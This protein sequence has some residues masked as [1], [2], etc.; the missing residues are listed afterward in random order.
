MKNQYKKH[1]IEK[2]NPTEEFIM[3]VDEATNNGIFCL[4]GIIIERSYYEDIVIKEIN[5][6]KN[7]F[8]EKTDIIFHYTEIKKSHKDFIRLTDPDIR[9]KFYMVLKKFFKNSQTTVISTYFY[10]D[11]MKNLYGKCCTSQYNVAFKY[12]IEN[13]VH[14]LSEHNGNGMI[15][16]ESRLL[17]ENSFLQ[18]SFYDYL[19]N[20]SELFS[21]KTISSYLKCLGFTV[22]GDNCIGLQLADFI[23]P[24][25]I[26]II[27]DSKDKFGI[28]GAIRSKIYKND[29]EYMSTLG[30][31][32]I[33][34]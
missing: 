19:T 18:K 17:N 8:F 7:N 1:G 30:I 10:M 20:G 16:M 5:D 3:F 32:N 22:K 14:F 25:I 24:T 15:M 13:Y 21:S 28:Q 26:R 23:P 29:S 27:T 12:L 33:L 2:I 6:I 4:S 9:N 11:H 34:G 31:R